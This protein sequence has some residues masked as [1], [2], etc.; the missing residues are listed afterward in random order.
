MPKT[1]QPRSTKEIVDA[2]FAGEYDREPT[3]AEQH[4]MYQAAEEATGV[5]SSDHLP[6]IEAEGPIRREE[7]RVEGVGGR[8]GLRSHRRGR[9]K[10]RAH[11][12]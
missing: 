7:D 5:Y 1:E 4:R 12:R 9:K 2:V 10:G 3:P 11:H 8:D 6:D